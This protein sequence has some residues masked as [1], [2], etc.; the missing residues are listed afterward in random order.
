MSFCSKALIWLKAIE[1]AI[2][3]HDPY[4][5]HLTVEP[6]SLIVSCPTISKIQSS[7]C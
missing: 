6:H 2:A 7:L 3:L 1:D 5:N 4:K